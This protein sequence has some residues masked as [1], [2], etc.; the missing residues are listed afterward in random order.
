MGRGATWTDVESAHLPESWIVVSQNPIIGTDQTCITFYTKLFELF[1]TRNPSTAT[2]KQYEE[3]GI[4]ATRTNWES[5][6][7]DLKKF[8]A[9]RREIRMFRP[10]GTN[11]DQKLRMTIARHLK[12]MGCIIYEAKKLDT[13]RM[14]LPPR[15]Q[16]VE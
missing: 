10:N 15:V 16:S 11:E 14:G 8:R 4:K 13:R 9:A 1:R 3:R 7:A 2:D 5:C 6:V 12:K